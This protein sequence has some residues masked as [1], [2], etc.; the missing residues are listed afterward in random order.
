MIKDQIINNISQTDQFVKQENKEEF[1]EYVDLFVQRLPRYAVKSKKHG[2]ITKKKPLS[3]IPILAHL[4]G[5]YS[6]GSLGKWYPSYAL[7][8]LDDSTLDKAQK[9]RESINLNTSNSILF[10]SESADSYH[11]LFKPTFNDKPPTI[12]LLNEVLKPFVLKNN[13]E[14]Y[15]QENKVCRLPFGRFSSST[16]DFEYRNL[17]DWTDKLYWFGKLNDF[18]LKSIPYPQAKEQKSLEYPEQNISSNSNIYEE[19]KFLYSNGLINKG[20]RHNEE[21]KVIYY[22]FRQNI[23]ECTAIEMTFKWIKRKNNGL[24]K[25]I[26]TKPEQVKN[27][28]IRQAQWIYRNFEE[29]GYYPDS[30]N[31]AYGGYIAKADIQRIIMITGGNIPRAKFL[32]NLIKYCYPRRNRNEINIHSD[33]LLRWS[34]ENYLRYIDEFK[35]QG[36]VKT[37]SDNYK[38]DEFSKAIKINWKF[39]SQSEAILIDGRAPDSLAET[40]KAAFEIDEFMSLLKKTKLNRQTIS[41]IIKRIFLK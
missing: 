41:E 6:V 26:L 2:W 9:I 31:N 11:I 7:L 21:W 8:D 3:D 23:P 5:L 4:E 39:R 13:I 34:K 20:S 29:K 22:L 28:I 30:V 17:S 24:S 19:G 32:Y 27:E 12:R 35:K 15:P 16:V 33:H 14:L 25:D 10:N 1:N 38:I 40:I 36:I 18:D 37:R